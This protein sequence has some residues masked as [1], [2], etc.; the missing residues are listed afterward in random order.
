[1]KVLIVN[2][3]EVTEILKMDACIEVMADAA[4]SSSFTISIFN[5]TTSF[6]TC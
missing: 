5:I 2:Q 6:T 1:M 3:Q 4:I